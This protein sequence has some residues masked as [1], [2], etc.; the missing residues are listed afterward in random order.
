[1]RRY[2]TES[3]VYYHIAGKR[4]SEAFNELADTRAVKGLIDNRASHGRTRSVEELSRLA[5]TRIMD[6]FEFEGRED[7]RQRC[8]QVARE[9][10]RSADD[11]LETSQDLLAV[12]TDDH[13]AADELGAVREKIQLARWGLYRAR[14]AT[15]N[16]D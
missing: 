10:L 3:E 6:L 9:L 4:A 12:W 14:E 15:Q 1:M 13:E 16:D 11:N 7:D 2:P 8:I 5:F